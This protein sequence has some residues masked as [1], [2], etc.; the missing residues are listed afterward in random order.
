[1]PPRTSWTWS[2]RNS[3]LRSARFARGCTVPDDWPEDLP[4]PARLALDLAALLGKLREIMRQNYKTLGKGI[5]RVQTRWCTH[6]TPQLFRERWRKLFNDFEEDPHDPSRSSELY[7]MLSHDGLHNRQFIETVFADAAVTEADL[8]KRL[9]HLHELYR[10][11]LA[12]FQFICP[13]EYGITPE[14][15]EEIGFLTSCLCSRTSSRISRVPRRAR[16]FAVSTSPRRVTSTRCSTSC[17][18]PSSI[19]HAKDPAARLLCQHHL[20]GV[21]AQ[22]FHHT[23]IVHKHPRKCIEQPARWIVPPRPCLARSSSTRCSSASRKAHTRATSSASTSMHDMRSPP[24]PDARSPRTWTLTRP[25]ASSRH[26]AAAPTPS[27]AAWSKAPPS[28]LG[29]H[30]PDRQF[31][32]I[33]NRRDS[34]DTDPAPCVKLAWTGL[35]NFFMFGIHSPHHRWG[36]RGGGYMG[37]VYRIQKPIESRRVGLGA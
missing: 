33:K 15:K 6:E 28:F 17:S 22:L 18:L 2:R 21:R 29:Q 8:D 24:Y 37:R 4:P 30:D 13:R 31:I 23:R 20:R 26:T 19:G 35:T 27:N 5:E 12:L 34:V 9:T 7:D 1:M 10:K 36:G 3:R 16:A 11:A 14:E 32:P 25:W